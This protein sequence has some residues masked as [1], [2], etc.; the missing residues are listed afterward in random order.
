MAMMLV[1]VS[2]WN[3]FVFYIWSVSADYDEG[4]D[5]PIVSEDVLEES[6]ADD[7]SEESTEISEEL[8]DWD[9]SEAE[10]SSDDDLSDDQEEFAD[11]DIVF[12]D[13]SE[14]EI[15]EED[16]VNFA[17]QAG[18]MNLMS[19]W[20]LQNFSWTGTD[21]TPGATGVTYTFSYTTQ[22]EVP[23]FHTIFRYFF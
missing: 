2:V 18:E 9:V 22:T 1:L 11:V 20:V 3:N 4:L 21:L 6:D 17:L 12:D 5:T 7:V 23:V 10:E 16:T 19:Q 14:G 13:E 8:D 15:I